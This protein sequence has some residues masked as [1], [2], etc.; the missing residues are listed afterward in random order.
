MGFLSRI[1][2]FF[3]DRPRSESPTIQA[4]YSRRAWIQ[5]QADV[6]RQREARRDKHKG[7]RD[8]DQRQQDIVHAALRGPRH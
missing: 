4:I 1:A 8:I 5:F 7:T 3:A 6:R 2:A